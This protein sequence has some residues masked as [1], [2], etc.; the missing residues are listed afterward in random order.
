MAIFFIIF[1]CFIAL[2]DMAL[3]VG[4]SILVFLCAGSMFILS[5]M[6]FKEK[7]L[8]WLFFITLVVFLST[9]IFFHYSEFQPF[10]GEGDYITYDEQAKKMAGMYERGQLPD[11]KFYYIPPELETDFKN[12][13][14]YYY[15]YY[16]PAFIGLIYFIFLPSIIIPELI[17][18]WLAAVSAVLVY[19]TVRELGAGLRW[20]FWIGVFSAI[21][22]SHLFY[23]SFM[24]KD[25][26]VIPLALVCLL[27]FIKIIRKFSWM[28][29]LPVCLALIVLTHL[30]FY[31]AYAI[32]ISF[33]ICWFLFSCLDIKKRIA[34]GLVMVTILGFI[35]QFSLGQGY[36]GSKALGEF[37]NEKAITYYREVV[38]S[39]RPEGELAKTSTEIIKT[40]FGSPFQFVKNYLFSFL[41]VM[42]GPFPWQ[43][44]QPRHALALFETLPWY[45]LL[46]FIS[47]GVINSIKMRK[48]E[49]AIIVFFG[50]MLAA[51]LA[52]FV[53]NLGT[54]TRIRIPAFIAFLYLIPFAFVKNEEI[55]V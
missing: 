50:V 28:K 53:S 36:M 2:F 21:Y 13:Y 29:F 12:D 22:P 26:I 30:R 18:V 7:E 1:F 23:A 55:F 3:V 9:T 31:V 17:G 54:I 43:I 32:I 41:E 11:F 27:F 42:L 47:K 15:S 52:L 44:K 33:I 45:F 4:M 51:A 6:G 14:P 49:V 38:Y 19:I 34:V 46:F 24:L 8:Y 40:G 48:K 5:Q 39:L 37:L 20:A 10:G 25:A 16:Y 35:P